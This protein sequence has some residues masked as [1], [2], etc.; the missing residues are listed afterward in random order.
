MDEE[1]GDVDLRADAGEAAGIGDVA[2]DDLA[3]EA[4]ERA[5]S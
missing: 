2:A 3:A 5:G 4:L 1:V